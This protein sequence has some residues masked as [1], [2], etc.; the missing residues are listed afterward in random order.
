MTAEIISLADRRAGKGAHSMS[1]LSEDQ[2]ARPRRR[3]SKGD[4]P[5]ILELIH[6]IADDLGIDIE[7]PF[8]TKPGSR[9]Q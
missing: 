9:P 8:R 6:E 5:S 4:K 1:T 3:G 7:A 2:A